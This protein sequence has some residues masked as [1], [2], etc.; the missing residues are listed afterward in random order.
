VSGAFDGVAGSG[1][2]S[3]ADDVLA[4]ARD[5]V[6][7]AP[8]PAVREQAQA[9][10]DRLS[11]P[12]RVAIAGRVKAGKSTLLNALVGERLAPTDAGECTRIVS[13]YRRGQGYEVVAK[14]RDGRAEPLAFSRSG[15]SLDIKLGALEEKA[16]E[17]I[18]VTWPTSSLETVTLIDTPGLASINDENSRRT[19]DFLEADPDRP[20]DAD[21]VVYLI[22]HAHRADIA[23]LDAFM[24]RTVTAASP[25]NAVA[26]LSRADEIGAGR[27]DAMES[28]ARIAARYETDPQ[29][30]GLCAAVVPMAG[31]LAETG[32]T[33][34]ED[35]VAALRMLANTDESTLERMLLSADSFCELSSS[36]L[37]VESRRDLLARL[38]MF[39]V[40]LALQE[41]KAGRGTTAATLG[42]ILVEHSGL[43][44]LRELLTRHFAP[45]ARVLQARS[46]LTALRA[47]ARSVKD[48][49]P[50]VAADIE[51]RVEQVEATTVQFAQV[52]AAHLVGSGAVNVTAGERTELERLLSGAG[53]E[54]VLG[55]GPSASVDDVRNA[56]LA[57][58]SRWRTAAGDPLADPTYVEVCDVAART[59]EQ[60]YTTHLGTPG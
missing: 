12:L 41:I 60:I 32:L 59:L 55:L 8:N 48:V 13:C 44:A 24:D 51:R 38:G 5:L 19:R 4:V 30:R 42:P 27:L 49:S 17:T 21:A 34:R 56:A 50:A 3:V 6:A 11:G 53:A 22:R 7:S 36:E 47:I 43:T 52:R 16:I 46:A 58:I 40:R 26:V 28:S 35:E 2:S 39:G 23:F 37:T 33:L 10:V 1:A 18:E 9:V 15:G 45:R 54:V 14:M 31:L 57:G 29:L 25:V 20:S